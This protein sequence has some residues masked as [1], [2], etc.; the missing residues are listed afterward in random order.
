VSFSITYTTFPDSEV[1][2]EIVLPE[3]FVVPG[4]YRPEE[5]PDPLPAM[6]QSV[7]A[8]YPVVSDLQTS[9]NR[10]T[11]RT[12]GTVNSEQ[13]HRVVANVCSMFVS[14]VPKVEHKNVPSS[15][16]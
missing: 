10:I 2:V 8:K 12:T 11:A 7:L 5:D 3:A 13:L 15:K 16:Q 6:V 9:G 14:E 4:T 1:H